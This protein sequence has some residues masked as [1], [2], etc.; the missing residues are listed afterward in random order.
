LGEPERPFRRRILLNSAAIGAGNAWAMVVGVVSLP[1]LLRGLGTDGFGTWV[2]LQTFSA[3]T[4]WFSL[5]DAGVGTATTTTVSARA[6][7]DDEAGVRAA[8]SASLAIF[9]GLGVV[10]AGLLALIGPRALPSLFNTPEPLI[11]PLR[12]A[13][14]IFAGQLLMDQATNAAEAALEG[15]QR[16][17]LSRLADG[18]R[19]TLVAAATVGA[20]LASG[21]LPVVALAAAVAAA[22]A[23][24][25]AVAMLA[26]HLPGRLERPVGTEVRALFV[27]GRAIALLRPIGVLHRQIDRLVVGA[28][29][30]PSS[31]ALVEVAIQIQNGAEAVLSASSYSA[32]PAAS[33]VHA[34]ED[35]GSLR[36]LLERGTRYS[37]LV[38]LPVTV[39][40]A[41]L[42]GPLVQVW[43]GDGYDEVPRL[44]AVALSYTAVTAVLQV[45]SNLLVGT[46]RSGSVLR[47]ALVAVSVNLIASMVLVRVVGM[48]GVFV[49]SL[50]GALALVPWV[51][52]AMLRATGL[53]AAPFLRSAV[54]PCLAPLAV[55]TVTVLAL[56]TLPLA[57]LPLLLVAG[58]GGAAAYGGVAL[59]IGLPGD[60]RARVGALLKRRLP[61]SRPDR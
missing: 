51:G 58:T 60:D 61:G 19:R 42:A 11:A 44:A 17:D 57:P 20:A 9:A 56:R 1:L 40:A 16:V 46:G 3:T 30:G 12:V 59:A 43:L 7:T 4:G 38:T 6:A 18:I 29:L 26:R 13:V 37:L 48:V 35:H 52:R 49:A 8:V 28:A 15:L 47:G 55:L 54:L 22:V 45:G 23:A 33:W 31:V 25:V 5:A 14:A 2:L 41:L 32:I 36:E 27:H 10:C 53:S 24:I 34:R 39:G 50:L 21:Q